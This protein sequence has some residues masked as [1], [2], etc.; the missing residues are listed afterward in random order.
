MSAAEA[1]IPQRGRGVAL[2]CL[3]ILL[4]AT[5][6]AAAKWLTS[7]FPV[8]EI[9]FFRSV[10]AL[11]PL[12]LF[13]MRGAGSLTSRL[14]TARPWAH[15]ARG[16]V[17]LVTLVSFF[18]ALL[19]LP[20]ATVTVITLANPVFMLLIG[21]LWL[22]ERVGGVQWLAVALGLAGVVVVC[23]WSGLGMDVYS[24]MAIV[25]A[26][27]YAL[28]SILTR[29]LAA[30]DSPL[31][32]TFYGTLVMLVASLC[33]VGGGW[34]WP[35]G[36]EWLVLILL[37]LAGAAANFVNALS[38]RHVE[39]SAVAPLEYTILLWAAGFGYLLFGEIPGPNALLGGVLIVAS[40]VL[41]ARQSR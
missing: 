38:L 10:F 1:F 19:H 8:G 22:R 35:Q 21:V 15:L 41:A 29:R 36:G 11:I 32:I 40:G 7:G 3:A 28:A 30:T 31:S 17:V 2:Y 23:G 12:M 25:S 6:D 39:L 33:T 27:S 13:G 4:L 14:K 20:L 18:A 16:M 37:G 34:L 5:M 26:F 24:L 9:V